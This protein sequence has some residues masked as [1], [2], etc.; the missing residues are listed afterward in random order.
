MHFIENTVFVVEVPVSE[1]SQPEVKAAKVKEMHNLE[2]YE[3]FKLMEDVFHICIGSYLVITGKEKHDGQKTE[4]KV[5]FVARGFQEI[6][7][8]Q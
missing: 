2:D 5:R 8:P 4:F 7:K 1:H 3:T 6:E